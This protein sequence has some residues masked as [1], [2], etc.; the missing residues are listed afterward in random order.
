MNYRP[1]Q[2]GLYEL[3]V[4]QGANP[5]DLVAVMLESDIVKVDPIGQALQTQTGRR[6][7]LQRAAG[8][9][10]ANPV[11]R[12]VAVQA[13]TQAVMQGAQHFTKPKEVAPEFKGE[14]MLP[15]HAAASASNAYH[16]DHGEDVHYTADDFDTDTHK[17]I[18]RK[19]REDSNTSVTLREPV[20]PEGHPINKH[21]FAYDLTPGQ[22]EKST[23][24]SIGPDSYGS[25][26]HPK[27]KDMKGADKRDLAH[28]DYLKHG[29]LLHA[30][31][32]S[33]TIAYENPFHPKHRDS[34]ETSIKAVHVN[35]KNGEITRFK[36]PLNFDDD[37]ARQFSVREHGDET[38][39]WLRKNVTQHYN[40]RVSSGVGDL[41]QHRKVLKLR[42]FGSGL[43]PDSY[44]RHYTS[45]DWESKSRLFEPGDKV[46]FHHPS[47]IGSSGGP[48]SIYDAHV[49][50][51]N[52][53][54][55]LNV[56]HSREDGNVTIP[57]SNVFRGDSIGHENPRDETSPLKRTQ[58]PNHMKHY[59]Q[60]RTSDNGWK[61]TRR[62]PLWNDGPGSFHH[63]DETHLASGKS[64][65][66]LRD[67]LNNFEQHHD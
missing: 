27:Y 41:A 50:S 23:W 8:A 10:A 37:G 44:S 39:K 3:R 15:S 59:I 53:D 32:S 43:D 38:D 13:G 64:A 54:G 34:L 17:D 47:K 55:S 48:I 42:G 24:R 12:A 1:A 28:E 36:V 2:I 52:D 25:W 4:L 33:G 7:F 51:V 65:E 60:V 21:A 6:G 19:S 22:R 40:T 63:T 49:H 56:V 5:T 18:T 57:A 30:K 14:P 46:S 9:V 11:A 31:V 67:F 61:V 29:S 35:D 26:D 66:E 45:K 62:G 58:A 16:R 20:N